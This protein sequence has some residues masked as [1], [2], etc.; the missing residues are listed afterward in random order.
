MGDHKTN[1]NIRVRQ[2]RSAIGGTRR[3]RESLKCLGLR[4]IGSAATVP[5][6]TSTRGLIRTVAHLVVVDE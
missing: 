5:D 4:R 2:V 6:T 3:Q 1:G